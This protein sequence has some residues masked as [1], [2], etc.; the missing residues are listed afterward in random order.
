MHS[1]FHISAKA[2]VTKGTDVLLLRDR[3]SWDLPGGRAESQ[4]HIHGALTRE[5]SEELPGIH[6]IKIGDLIGWQHRTIYEVPDRDLVLLIFRVHA[7]LPH[8]I[9]L[10]A[11]HDTALWM[12]QPDARTVLADLAIQWELLR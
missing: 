7:E 2:L 6:N 9:A 5:L 12:A 10:S 4:E 8:P 11:E 1:N 3:S